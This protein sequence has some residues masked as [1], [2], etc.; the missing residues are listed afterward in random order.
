[1]RFPLAGPNYSLRS[2]AKLVIEGLD[3][4]GH[5]GN[6]RVERHHTKTGVSVFEGSEDIALMPGSRPAECSTICEKAVILQPNG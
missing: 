5:S 6:N 2:A 1:M 4:C 3:P